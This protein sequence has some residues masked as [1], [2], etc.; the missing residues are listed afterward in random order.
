MTNI[1]VSFAALSLPSVSVESCARRGA[2]AVA[3]ARERAMALKAPLPT[4]TTTTA[5]SKMIARRG[6]TQRD[7][8]L[9]WL[10]VLT[11]DANGAHPLSQLLPSALGHI[12]KYRVALVTM[13]ASDGASSRQ[14]F[15][16]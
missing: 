2:R 13:C 14:H 8:S 11:P 12:S 1:Q 16:P 15:F 3:Q 5:I 7:E 4:T 6:G 10:A 9:P